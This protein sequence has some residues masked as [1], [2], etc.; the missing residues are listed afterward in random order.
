MAFQTKQI[1]IMAAV[2]WKDLVLIRSPVSS[3]GTCEFVVMLSGGG[4]GIK[5]KIQMID[6]DCLF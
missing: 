6:T 3:E 2:V 4:G 5:N 1:R